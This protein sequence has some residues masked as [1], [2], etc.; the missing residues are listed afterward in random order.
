MT[1]EDIK[2]VV[3]AAISE[4]V[5]FAWWHYVIWAAV[6]GLAVFFG[7]YLAQRGKDKAI[8]DSIKELTELVE[9]VKKEIRANEAIAQAKRKMK[10]E[11]CLEALSVLDAH[12]SF[13]FK[14][15]GAI[16][17]DCTTEKAREV[18]SKLILACD[19]S[20]IIELFSNIVFGPKE[21]SKGQ[22]G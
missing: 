21:G 5:G 19:N 12:L 16:P 4:G 10:H 18:H 8:K 3:E 15:H 17:Q 22:A 11:A 1:P 6:T 2:K 9:G 20:K 14:H 13:G 7:A